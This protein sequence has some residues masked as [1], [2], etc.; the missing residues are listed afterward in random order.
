MYKL[1]DIT[2]NL[3]IK[4]E[5]ALIRLKQASV[6]DTYG[7]FHFQR[8][9]VNQQFFFLRTGIQFGIYRCNPFKSKSGLSLQ[10]NMEPTPTGSRFIGRCVTGMFTQ[11]CYFDK[12][13]KE[14][15]EIEEFVRTHLADVTDA[16]A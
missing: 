14:S 15:G 10:V 4:P 3:R 1:H 5:E 8:F 11:L 9:A 12:A 2:F 6:E 13:R 16:G 7:E